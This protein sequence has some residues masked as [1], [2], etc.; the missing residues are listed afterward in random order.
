MAEFVV[1]ADRF[2][3]LGVGEAY[4]WTTLGP[5][6]ELVQVAPAPRLDGKRAS[7][8][9]RLYRPLEHVRLPTR[10]PQNGPGLVE[11]DEFEPVAATQMEADQQ[12]QGLP[13]YE[14]DSCEGERHAVDL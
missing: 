14:L 6:V 12:R 8:S 3:Q 13:D 4:V 11:E 1:P 2:K 7:C 5:N 10:T 9:E